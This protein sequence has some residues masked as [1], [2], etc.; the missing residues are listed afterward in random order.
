MACLS[1]LLSKSTFGFF[2]IPFRFRGAGWGGVVRVTGGGTLAVVGSSRN[3]IFSNFSSI[4]IIL[5]PLNAEVAD[6]GEIEQFCFIDGFGGGRGF[7]VRRFG[8]GTF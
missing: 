7:E 4:V 5:S 2:N 1:K 8:D 3:S 6:E